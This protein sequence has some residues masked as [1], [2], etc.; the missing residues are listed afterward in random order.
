MLP[1]NVPDFS[2][3]SPLAKVVIELERL[4]GDLGTSTT[5]QSVFIQLKQ[6]FQLMTSIMSARIEGNRTSI[7]EVVEGAAEGAK[8]RDK[9]ALGHDQ[10]SANAKIS[11]GVKEIILL[12]NAAS[13]I[14]EH[15]RP[16]TPITHA[17][18]R[19]LHKIAVRG[20]I[21]EGDRT[22][23]A[24]R[25][26]DVVIQGSNHVPPAFM[27]VQAD[28][29]E[30]LDFINHEDDRSLDLL[31]VAI[32]HH[33]FVWIH[34]FGNGNGR[35]C[36]L[37]TYAIMVSQGFTA[38]TG[39]RAIDPTAVFGADRSAYYQN[40]EAADSLEPATTIAWCTYLL[41]GM[42]ADLKKLERLGDHD[43]VINEL[44]RPSLSRAVAAG[45]IDTREQA[46]LNVVANKT[47]IKA[48][49]LSGVFTGTPV[50]RSQFIRRLIE[51]RL[52]EPIS[53]G[54]RTYRLVMSPGALT[55]FIFRQLDEL[56]FL[57]Q[58]LRDD[59]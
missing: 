58:I 23:G 35:T 8:N 15:V 29:Q 28:M 6:L 52:I 51:R 42:L 54:K 53:E 33:R 10:Y 2:F 20:L 59:I 22:P 45:A 50:A 43:F 12:E 38:T 19:E 21:R 31:K 57:P 1:I 26:S 36:R 14:D 11:D 17:L 39:Y 48:S 44:L 30:L 27:S 16:G 46:T 55:P 13:F 49:D 9:L 4:R 5:P 40:L 34:P 37:L 41:T 32:A 3:N 25:Q 56:G 18:V 47:Y 24:Y 7:V